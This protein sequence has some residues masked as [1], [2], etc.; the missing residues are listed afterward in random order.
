MLKRMTWMRCALLA[1]ALLT[2]FLSLTL[3]IGAADP[4]RVY[5][6][7]ADL[8]S[9]ADEAALTA[10]LDALSEKHGIDFYLATYRAKNRSDDF[11]GDD[12]CDEVS[13]ISRADAV[14]LIITYDRSDGNYYYDIYA[15]GRPDQRISDKEVNYILDADGVYNNIKS[16]RIVEGAEQFF[17]LSAKGY[18][19]RVGVSYAIIIPVCAVLAILISLL[20]VK[21]VKDSYSKKHASVDYPLDR[22]AKLEL[23][24][25]SDTFT[26]TAVTRT[27]S[28]PSKSSGGGG[29]GRS[30]HGGGGGHRGGR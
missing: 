21:G 2:A 26:G 22:F 25:R 3:P 27:Y 5:D 1:A 28:P 30:A 20:V 10:K 12:Y 16:G 8:L 24:A 6:T 17:D 14:L 4:P 19:G 13:D 15:Y 18:K 9:D 7:T 11:Y 23:T 29:G